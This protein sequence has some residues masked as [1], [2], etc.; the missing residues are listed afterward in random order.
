[1]GK[2][3]KDKIRTVILLVCISVSAASC[4]HE[5]ILDQNVPE[6]CFEREVLPIFR[7]SCSITGCHDGTGESHYVFDNYI[8]ISHSV[9]SGI[10]EERPAYKA[11]IQSFGE[12]RMPP[13]RS[14]SLENRTILRFWILQGANPTSCQDPSEQPVGY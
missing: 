11:V 4:R 9:V 13:D 10:P 8:D 5:A 1:M 2:R 3:R 7:N 14:L 6:I 12:G